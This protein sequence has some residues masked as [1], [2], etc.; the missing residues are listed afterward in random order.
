MN[1]V[2]NKKRRVSEGN[3]RKQSL[4]YCIRQ[5]GTNLLIEDAF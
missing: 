2:R 3:Y 4:G 1:F 5:E